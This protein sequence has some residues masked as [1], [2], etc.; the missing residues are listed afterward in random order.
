MNKK[1]EEVRDEA[2]CLLQRH[3]EI[4]N[5]I[6]GSEVSVHDFMRYI[7]GLECCLKVVFDLDFSDTV[8][9]MSW[10]NEKVHEYFG[11]KKSE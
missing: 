9:L 2:F 6:T 4:L 11:G 10:F 3:I 8:C 7:I 1:I 5:A